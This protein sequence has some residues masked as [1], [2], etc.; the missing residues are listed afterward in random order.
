MTEYSNSGGYFG[1]Q[2]VNGKCI[3]CSDSETALTEISKYEKCNAY[4]K[5]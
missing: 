5:F 1:W 4:N 3:I 2:N